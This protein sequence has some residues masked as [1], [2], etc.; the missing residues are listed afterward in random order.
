M[1]ACPGRFRLKDLLDWG[2]STGGV[3]LGIHSDWTSPWK[4]GLVGLTAAGK[5]AVEKG[6]AARAPVVVWLLVESQLL[7]PPIVWLAAGVLEQTGKLK[8][9][10]K[11][12]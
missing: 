9:H 4:G 2:H 12:R 5:Q 8:R 7:S 3:E 6:L 10:R 11:T 1:E